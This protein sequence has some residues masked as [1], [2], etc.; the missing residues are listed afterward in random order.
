MS[1]WPERVLITGGAGLV[2][3]HIADALIA[4]DVAEIVVLDN[5]SRGRRENL[6]SALQNGRVRIVSGDVR[7]PE[8]VARA[9]DGVGLVFHQAAI[10]ITQ[11]A[12]E[13]RLAKDV[14]VDG[15]FN[16]LEAAVRG[17]VRKVVAA[18]SA[19][20]YGLAEQF[21][22]AETHHPY[23]NRT[24]YGAAKLFNESLLRS[25]HDMYGLDYIALRYFNVYGPRMDV[26]GAYTEVMIRWMEAIAAG[27][28]PVV[29]GDGATTM[30]FVHVEDIARANILAA[31]ATATDTVLNIGSGRETSLD[32]L[33]A[34]LLSIMGSPLLPEHAPARKVNPVTRRLAAVD[35]AWQHIGFRT[36]IDLDEGLRSLV[37]W[38][39]QERSVANPAGH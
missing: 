33:A 39:Q 17:G 28:S 18:S 36:K 19:S 27:R 1:A 23:A 7:D 14:L 29:F 9:M 25:F 13:P 12:E 30:D 34:M 24:L 10:R 38:W 16:V 31:T 2:G 22:T 8:A 5:F 35:D 20:V 37:A 32:E 4:T 21:P 6:G 26:Y 11:C 3:S 15:T